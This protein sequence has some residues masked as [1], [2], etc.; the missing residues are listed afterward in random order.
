MAE[1]AGARRADRTT[2]LGSAVEQHKGRNRADARIRRD[3]VVL[4]RDDSHLIASDGSAFD[5]SEINASEPVE[6]SP[7]IIMLCGYFE[8]SGRGAWPLLEALPPAIVLGCAGK[9]ETC[10][11][12]ALVKLISEELAERGPGSDAVIDCYAQA[13]FVQVLRSAINEGL[14][15]G[16]LTALADPKIGAALNLIHDR[17]GDPWNLEGLASAVAMGR[18]A[19]SQRFR[20]LAGMP[21]MQYLAQWRMQVAGALLV[22][23]QASIA[24]IAERSGYASEV[25]FRKSFRRIMG[26]TPGAWRRG[27]A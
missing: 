21:A 18:T 4:P 25:A 16:L 24:D 2:G 27:A 3:L 9:A 11:T 13:L 22:R 19:F 23:T 14:A 1:G 20:E 6:A 10:R 8:F 5:P 12:S 17:P 26:V 7:D 15:G